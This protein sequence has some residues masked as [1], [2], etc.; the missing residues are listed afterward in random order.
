M[1][2]PANDE[3]MSP[4]KKVGAAFG[5]HAGSFQK[6]LAAVADAALEP[7]R[8]AREE[9]VLALKM[10]DMP[11]AMAFVIDN[12]DYDDLA[13]M[14]QEALSR[15]NLST[16]F[17]AALAEA[18]DLDARMI[19][20]ATEMKAQIESMSEQQHIAFSSAIESILPPGLTASIKNIRGGMTL[21]DDVREVRSLVKN[22]TPA[23]IA[24]AMTARSAR[25]NS[26]AV[27]AAISDTAAQI[28]PEK[29]EKLITYVTGNFTPAEIAVLYKRAW[30]ATEEVLGA[31]AKGDFM[32]P[33]NPRK[34]RV[35]GQSLHEALS[36]LEE[37]LAQAEITLPPAL[38]EAI[39][40]YTDT[41]RLLRQAEGIRQAELAKH[42]T[43][44]EISVKPMTVRRRT[45]KGPSNG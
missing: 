44:N 36:V 4:L 23:H 35:F 45:A 39:A 43:Q 26:D 24:T 7:M 30:E 5:A 13:F 41:N 17:K 12:L 8:S 9:G 33:E 37:G 14:T 38:K 10:A 28:T 31:A 15:K 40:D 21:E 19:K 27:I 1:K 6:T 29:L 25:T 42:G 11:S 18:P 34:L 3:D 20:R 22:L 16:H 32:T 2:N